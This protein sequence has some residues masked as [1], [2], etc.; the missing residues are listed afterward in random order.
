M[1][2]KQRACRKVIKGEKSRKGKREN[3]PK[4]GSATDVRLREKHKGK[5]VQ[6]VR[7]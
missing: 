2:P 1:G 3:V 4:G 5:E 6:R 7:L